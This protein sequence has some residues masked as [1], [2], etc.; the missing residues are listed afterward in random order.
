MEKTAS[1]RKR[2]RCQ[3]NNI[4]KSLIKHLLLP[5]EMRD[6]LIKRYTAPNKARLRLMLKQLFE[7]TNQKDKKVV[8]KVDTLR[9]L[10]AQ[11]AV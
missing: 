8:E 10:A 6:A 1:Y 2:I 7:V 3:L 4:Y 9:T 5:K 11:I